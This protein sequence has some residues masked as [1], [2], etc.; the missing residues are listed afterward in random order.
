MGHLA[1]AVMKDSKSR[2]PNYEI[3]QHRNEASN[4]FLPIHKPICMKGQL[5]FKYA[6]D[7]FRRKDVPISA[8]PGSSLNLVLR[9]SILV[10]RPPDSDSFI[11]HV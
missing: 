11:F 9:L 5:P 6:S 2:G 10:T 7:L 8:F 3:L 4:S 1:V